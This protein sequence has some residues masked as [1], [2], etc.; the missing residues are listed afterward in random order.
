MQRFE[1]QPVFVREIVL[2]MTDIK[3]VSCIKCGRSIEIRGQIKCDFSGLFEF[4]LRLR[5]LV[6]HTR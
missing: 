6:K 4:T 1:M 5:C 3:I 2:N